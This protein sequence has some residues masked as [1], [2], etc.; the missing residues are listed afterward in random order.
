MSERTEKEL[1]DALTLDDLE[2]KYRA[3]AEVVGMEGLKKLCDHFGGS[4]IYIPQNKQL[5]GNRREIT[6]YRE[7]DGS[8]IKQLAA[9]YGVSE[10]TV[11]NL[12]R[13]RLVT[14]KGGNVLGQMS[15]ADM[16]WNSS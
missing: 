1:L 15:L 12:V 3:I 2:E 10:S 11:Y 16:E 9:R 6:I 4:N 14:K 7:Y 13:D 8:N 5:I